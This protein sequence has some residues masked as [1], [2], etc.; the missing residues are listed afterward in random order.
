VNA[1]P[2]AK[3]KHCETSPNYVPGAPSGLG[4]NPRQSG[5]VFRRVGPAQPNP[6]ENRQPHQSGRDSFH[7]GKVYRKEACKTG[8]QSEALC[9][10]GIMLV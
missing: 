1:F 9:R 10:V 3:N 6:A 8:L 5:F 7:G 4:R 2:S